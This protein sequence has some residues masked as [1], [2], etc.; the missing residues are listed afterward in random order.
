MIY[1]D[2]HQ[3]GTGVVINWP[4]PAGRRTLRIVGQGYQDFDSL[5]TVTPGETI[6]LKLITLKD[7]GAKP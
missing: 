2:G 1:I 4:I 3:I 6:N 7:A 5:L